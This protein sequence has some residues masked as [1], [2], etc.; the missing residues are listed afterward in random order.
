[1]VYYGRTMD[2]KNINDVG[3]VHVHSNL[4]HKIFGKEIVKVSIIYN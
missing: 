1:M 2:G 4:G 3:I